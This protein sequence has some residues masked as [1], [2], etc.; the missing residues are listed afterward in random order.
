MHFGIFPALFDRP[1]KIRFEVQEDD[2]V[3]ELFLRRHGITNLPWIIISIVAFFLPVVA[4][5]LDQF[6]K[7]NYLL[8]IST[9]IL[10]SALIVYYL[11]IL[12]YIIENFLNWY[13]NIYIVTNKH[14]FSNAFDSV[15]SRTTNEAELNDIESISA[16]IQGIFGELFNFGDVVIETAA[17]KLKIQFFKVPRPDFVADRVRDL[18]EAIAGG[19]S[20]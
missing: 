5:Q 6:L 13:F 1:D 19:D 8:Q 11:L 14:L 16:K 10:V 4:V 17:E 2:E 12:A 9:Q 15:L 18:Q 7:T 3:I 20:P